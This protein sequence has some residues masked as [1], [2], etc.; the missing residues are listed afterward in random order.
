MLEI[1]SQKQRDASFTRT[2][3]SEQIVKRRSKMGAIVEQHTQS[4]GEEN[5]VS[6]TSSLPKDSFHKTKQEFAELDPAYVMGMGARNRKE[7]E[8]FED[9]ALL[10]L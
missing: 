4:F 3:A 9:S 6:N 7:G 10:F 5:F 2:R 1:G 8:S